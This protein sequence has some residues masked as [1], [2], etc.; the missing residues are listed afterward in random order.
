MLGQTGEAAARP[1]PGVPRAGSWRT[2]AG[3]TKLGA[4]SGL[5]AKIED[6]TIRAEIDALAARAS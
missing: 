5:F 2:L 3:G 4:V 1:W 6:A